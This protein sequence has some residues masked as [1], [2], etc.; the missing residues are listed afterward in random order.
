MLNIE[1][2]DIF[3]LIFKKKLSRFHCSI[4][5]S[6]IEGVTSFDAPLIFLIQVYLPKS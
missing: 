4:L 2:T 5:L 6:F 3:S 1:A